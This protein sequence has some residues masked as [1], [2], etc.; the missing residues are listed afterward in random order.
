MNSN[1]KEC[2]YCGIILTDNNK[3]RDHIEPV[4]KGKHR[5]GIKNYGKIVW[6]CRSCNL[7]KGNLSLEIFK[8]SKYYNFYCKRKIWKQK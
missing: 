7:A 3:T 1:E 2:F 5:R 4:N 6:A 8:E